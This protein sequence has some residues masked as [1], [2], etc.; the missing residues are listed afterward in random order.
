MTK[1]FGYPDV[2]TYGL[3]HSM[4]A[5]ARCYL[6]CDLHKV[7]MLAPSWLRIRGHIGPILRKE[8]DRRMYQRLFHFPDYVSGVRR[9]FLLSTIKQ[10]NV[11]DPACDAVLRSGARRIVVFTNKLQL[12]E[13]TYFPQVAGN[14]AKIQQ[15]LMAMT[16]PIYHPPPSLVPHLALHVR[17]GDFREAQSLQ[18]LRSGAR[19]SR[20]PLQWYCSILAGLRDKLGEIPAV[21]Y[22][23]GSDAALASLLAMPQVVRSPKQASITDM[24]AMSQAKLLISSGSGF[25]SWGT[26]LADSPRICFPGQRFARV[27]TLSDEFKFD[28]EPECESTSELSPAFLHYVATLLKAN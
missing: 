14:S 2:G 19:N 27:L 9:L 4:L 5:W 17:M 22:S 1:V 7:P 23:D 21:V 13:E 28:R 10:I 24:L 3:G 18:E 20:I 26:F 11:D 6:W 15:A 8:R 25:S 12:N 16:K